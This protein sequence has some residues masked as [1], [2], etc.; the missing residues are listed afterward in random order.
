MLGGLG[1]F[2]ASEVSGAVK[3][4]VIVYGLYGLTGL[5]VLCAFGYGL[6]ALHTILAQRYGAAPASL[7]IAGGLLVSAALA[8]ALA[9]YVRGRKRPARPMAATALAAAPIALQLLGSRRVWRFGVMA[10]LAALGIVLGRQIIKGG[11][12]PGEDA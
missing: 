10:G 6:D 3:R 12:E 8:L 1:A 11:D 9:A 2:L 5:L 4:N 7:M